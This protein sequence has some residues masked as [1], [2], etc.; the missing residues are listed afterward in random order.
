MSTF[1]G[2]KRAA[3][4]N[5]RAK[6]VHVMSRKGKITAAIVVV[7]VATLVAGSALALTSIA[8]TIGTIAGYDF[9]G[10]GPGHPIPATVQIQA[11]V[12]K[13]GDTVPWHYHK[14]PSYV[15]LERGTL[16]ELHVVAP[17][18]CASEEVTAG[19]AFVEP[20]GLVHT[21]TNS[22]NDAAVIWWSTVFPQSD[23]IADFSPAFKSGGVYPAT[24]PNCN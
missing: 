13:P 3:L 5:F 6:G 23:G 9:G 17:N 15:I 24:P 1:E 14:G 2:Y 16:T 4:A 12:M 10:F 18:Q 21:V 22:G 11:F 20:P 7:L 19:S 8:F